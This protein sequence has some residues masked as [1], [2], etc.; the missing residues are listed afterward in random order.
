MF[1]HAKLKTRINGKKIVGLVGT[2]GL[3]V[4]IVLELTRDH[5]QTCKVEDLCRRKGVSEKYKDLQVQHLSRAKIM[6][7]GATRILRVLRRVDCDTLSH[8]G[9]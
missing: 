8:I 3:D 5:D 7:W 4:L 1:G 2:L 6:Y 9:K